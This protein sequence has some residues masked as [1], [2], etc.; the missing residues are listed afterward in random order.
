MTSRSTSALAAA[1]A[2]ALLAVPALA[3][4][5]VVDS[6]DDTIV[7][8]PAPT[9]P[10]TAIAP[11]AAQAT[12]PAIAQPEVPETS[13][14]EPSL[15]PEKEVRAAT[16]LAERD[17][18]RI[19][20]VTSHK[21]HEL[22]K[23]VE[24]H[25][26]QRLASRFGVKCPCEFDWAL[27]DLSGSGESDLLLFPRIPGLQAAPGFDGGAFFVFSSTSEHDDFR[28]V[29]R[30]GAMALGIRKAR[31]GTTELALV[32]EHRYRRFVWR[33]GRF[34]EDLPGPLPGPIQ[35]NAI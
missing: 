17:G 26:V 14:S 12:P 29:L 24:D 25:I 33:G 5:S 3:Q 19:I 9:A 30:G 8:A 27:I 11:R 15:P 32:Q 1:L 20:D 16:E 2:V 13:Q 35:K 10:S 4:Q 7:P 28:P 23:V 21:G 6:T 18:F 22:R 31:D 34:V